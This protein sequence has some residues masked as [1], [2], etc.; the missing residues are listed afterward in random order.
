MQAE[1]FWHHRDLFWYTP[2]L[3]FN[4]YRRWNYRN[5]A[6]SPSPTRY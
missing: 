2:G 4:G 5:C 6:W 1:L 3:I